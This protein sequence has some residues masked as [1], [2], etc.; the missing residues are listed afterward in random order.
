MKN[1]GGN[2]MSYRFLIKLLCKRIEFSLLTFVPNF[3]ILT[4]AGFPQ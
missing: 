2:P 4:L 3:Y 1:S